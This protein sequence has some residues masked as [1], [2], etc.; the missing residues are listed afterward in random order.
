MAQ[1]ITKHQGKLINMSLFVILATQ[2]S[3][4]NLLSSLLNSHPDC[5]C[6]HELFNDEH[7]RLALDLRDKA[8]PLPTIEQRDEQP[9]TFLN[10][11]LSQFAGKCATGLKMTDRQHP[12]MF[13]YLLGNRAFKKVILRRRNTLKE[14][15]SNKIADKLNQWEVYDARALQHQRPAVDVQMA[16]LLQRID[17]NRQHFA[18]IEQTL[19]ESGQRYFCCEYEHIVQEGPQDQLLEFLGL[20]TNVTLSSPSVKQNDRCLPELI[21]NFKQLQ[22]QLKGSPYEWLLEQP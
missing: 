4:S 17:A 14:L 3:G 9:I 5:I 21:S 15:V 8:I 13:D 22:Q 7:I 1:I 19:N 20:Q 12:G 11:M 6:H 10:Q 16:D 2:R 18:A